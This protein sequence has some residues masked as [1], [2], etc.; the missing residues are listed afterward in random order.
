MRSKGKVKSKELDTSELDNIC[1]RDE[2]E[3]RKRINSKISGFQY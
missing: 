1:L 3:E 2:R